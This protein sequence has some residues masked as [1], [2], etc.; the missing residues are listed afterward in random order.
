MQNRRLKNTL[1]KIIKWALIALILFFIAR[2]IVTRWQEV[3]DYSWQIN[4][5]MF[6]FS[7]LVLQFGLFFKSFLWSL[8]LKCFGVSLPALRAFR[9]AY[10]SNLGRYVPGKIVQFVGVMYLAKKEG[11]R[12]DMAV[13][14]FALTQLFDTPAGLITVFLY[15]LILGASLEKMILYWPV[16]IILAV[17]TLLS[18]LIILVP[19]LLERLLN[20]LLRLIKQ[21]ALKFKLEKKTGFKLLFLYFTVWNIFGLSFYLFLR[22]VTDI[23]ASFFLE[24]C[25][26]Y[27]A[28]YLVGYWALFA[29]GGIGV[30]EGAMGVFL[31]EIGGIATAVALAVSLASRF[32][33]LIGELTVS[34]LAL[35]VGKNKDGQ[36]EK[37]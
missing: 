16:L 31:A 10:L 17:V 14:S 1:I 29:P 9:V 3:R 23:P 18:I 30:R 28:A 22:S 12:E 25:V 15:Y 27:T 11:V 33:F 26:V 6:V 8:V 21:P 24:A 32:W 13:S 37:K 7:I 5:A 4:W 2:Q 19:A 36:E 35:I 34:I 20:F